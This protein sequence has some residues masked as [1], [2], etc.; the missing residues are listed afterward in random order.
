MRFIVIEGPDGSGKD[1]QAKL[2]AEHLRKKGEQVVIRS[3][4]SYDTLTGRLCHRLLYKSGVVWRII[5]AFLFM[6]DLLISMAKLY[7]YRGTV[8]FVRYIGTATYMPHPL[9]TIVFKTLSLFLKIP[10]V[11]IYI[12]VEPE[13]CME[14]IMKRKRRRRY[15]MFENIAEMEMQRKRAKRIGVWQVVD[16]SGKIEEVHRRILSVVENAKTGKK[17]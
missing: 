17:I 1:T 8:I 15:E 4:P 10:E 12:D 7:S 13:E 3:H 2:L 11:W 5:V 6:I 9:D 14:R 16:G